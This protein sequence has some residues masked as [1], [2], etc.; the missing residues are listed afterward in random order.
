[1]R[2][3]D[4]SETFEFA[5]EVFFSRVLHVRCHSLVD[6]LSR[7]LTARSRWRT[8]F[9]TD[10]PRPQASAMTNS[11]E[12]RTDRQRDCLPVR[13]PVFALALPPEN[14][15]H[16]TTRRTDT[17]MHVL[18]Y[19]CERNVRVR[20]VSTRTTDRSYQY[21]YGVKCGVLLV[22]LAVLRRYH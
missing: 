10:M 7:M 5:F 17:N 12:T 19:C 2:A 4:G 11:V 18:Q 8:S 14:S 16:R 13:L 9:K 1:M 3:G 6:S 15:I 22:F 21:G 20:V